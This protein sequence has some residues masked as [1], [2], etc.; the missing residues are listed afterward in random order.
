LSSHALGSVSR[1]YYDSASDTIYAAMN[2]P[3]VVAHV[4]SISTKTGETRRLTDIK[5]P[6]IYQVTSL[7][8]DP[9]G[10][11]LFYTT[12]NLAY[13]D[14]VHFSPKTGKKTVLMKDVR[15][16]DLVFSRADKPLWGIRELNGLSTLVEL[17]PPYHDW[18][19]VVTFPYGT[20]VYDLDVSPDGTLLSASF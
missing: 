14:L 1:A 5:G 6:L 8:V 12:D 17:A 20:V 13:R 11:T 9:S 7:A 4:G 3:G 2:S 10:P 15:V 19:R 16:G 18:T